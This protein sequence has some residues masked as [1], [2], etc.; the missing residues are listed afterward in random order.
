M[1]K[2]VQTTAAA[3]TWRWND[4]PAILEAT[5]ALGLNDRRVARLLG[6]SAEFVHS[7][8]NGRKPIPHLRLLTLIFLVG[9]LTGDIGKQQPPQTR[10]ARRAQMA[11]DAAVG[12]KNL[13][14]LELLED[15]GGTDIGETNP[16]LVKKAFQLGL[17]AI[18]KLERADAA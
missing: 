1:S 17:A 13:A 8:A 5:K 14:T 16:E 11:I 12:W 6:V 3:A 7:W 18:A 2:S 15:V 10:Y 9:R 4:R